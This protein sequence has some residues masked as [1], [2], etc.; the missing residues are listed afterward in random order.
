MPD[1]FE[2]LRLQQ[3][4]ARAETAKHAHELF[5]ARERLGRLQAQTREAAR[6]A[7]KEEA[8]QQFAD[9]QKKAVAGVKNASDQYAAAVAK[10]KLLV[11]SLL[12][13]TDPR[14]AIE[15]LDDGVPILM[16]PV[17]IETRFRP[18]LGELW[19]RVYPDDCSV[20]TFEP[21]LSEDELQHVRAYWAGIFQAG[22]DPNQE[23]GAW[24]ALAA[25]H[26]PGRAEWLIAQHVPVNLAMRMT[27]TKPEDVVLT[28]VTDEPLP[29]DAGK[30]AT[31]WAQVWQADGDK[32]K[33]DAAAALLGTV[34]LEQARKSFV[35]TNVQAN[36]ELPL[37]RKD[38]TVFVEWVL[39]P[40]VDTENL[41][42]RAWARAATVDTLPDRFV[43]VGYNPGA[44][45]FV[46]VGN[47]IPSSLSVGPDPAAPEEQRLHQRQDDTGAMVFPDEMQWMVDFERAV[48]VGM[49]FRISLQAAN[50]TGGFQRVLVAGVRLTDTAD[51]SAQRLETLIAHHRFS[52]S[53]FA[54]VPQGT[55]TNNTD[56]GPAG[57]SR[58]ADADEAF[59]LLSKPSLFEDESDPLRKRDGQWLAEYLGIDPAALR[60]VV[61]ADGRDQSDARAMNVALWP[62]TLGYWMESMM[63]PLLDGDL[64]V[65]QTRDFFTRFVSGRGAI[66]AV[67]IGKQ[68]YGILPATAFSHMDWIG[69]KSTAVSTPQAKFLREL[70]RVL[71]LIG[72]DWEALKGLQGFAGKGGDP[73]QTLL[74]I[75]GLH[76]GSAELFQRWTESLEQLASIVRLFVPDYEPDPDAWMLEAMTHLQHLAGS[77]PVRPPELLNKFFIGKRNRVDK[78]IDTV[79]LSET[80]TLTVT[81]S[82]EKNYIE[83]L[84]AAAETSL[85][86]LYAQEGFGDKPPKELLYVMLRHALQLGY[87]DISLRL[88]V[89]KDLMT[90][91]AARQARIDQ[92]F[93]NIATEKTVAESRYEHLFKKE[94]KITGS[95]VQRVDEFI[96][97]SLPKLA[98]FQFVRPLHD[99]IAA[100]KQLQDASTA[101]LERAFV[102]HI[103]TCA[104]RLDSWILGLV[105]LQLARMRQI[106][107]DKATPVK[108]GI[109]LGAYA[110]VEDLRPEKKTLKPKTFE[111]D[112][113]LEKEFG[114][115]PQLVRDSNNFGYI[116]APSL[117]QAVAAAV[118]RNGYKQNASPKNRDTLAVNLTSERVRAAMAMIEGIR[119]GQS[120]GALLGYQF[121]RGLHDRHGEAEVDKFIFDLRAKFPLAGNKL[122]STFAA[123]LKDVR[124]I[125]A[126]NVVDGLA[127]VEHMRKTG[128]T[129]YPF[130]FD[131]LPHASDTEQVAI[132]KEAD[133]MRETHDA[134]SDL[135]TAEG[136]YQAILGNYDRAGS[137]YDAY[138][139]GTLPPEPQVVRAPASGKALT[140]RVALHLDPD[141]PAGSTPRSIAEPPL[142]AWLEGVL[143]AL[144]DIG[145]TVHFRTPGNVMDEMS[146]TLANLGL[147]ARDV[148][149]LVH[150]GRQAMN[151]LDDRI[152]RFV[153]PQTR[154]DE[155]V[156]IEYRK[157]DPGIPIF[158]VM[159][160]VR[161]LRTLFD[162]ARPLRPTDL[163][164]AREAATSDD[165]ALSFNASAIMAAH[166]RLFLANGVLGGYIATHAPLLDDQAA[167]HAA[168]VNGIDADIDALAT[169]LDGAAL[170]GI[171]QTGW[172]FAYDTRRGVY[173][174]I[175]TKVAEA[176]QKLA[177]RDVEFGLAMAGLPAA[178][179]DAERFDLLYRAERLISTT[180]T[181][182]AT[183]L[184]LETELT[185]IK[186]P[187]F[188]TQ[189]GLLQNVKNTSAQT[190]SG[191]L[192]QVKGLPELAPFTF[193]NLSFDDEERTLVALAED[194]FRLAVAVEAE[195]KKR[196]KEAGDLLT[197]ANGAADAPARNKAF[198]AAAKAMFG[199]HFTVIPRFHLETKQANEIEQSRNAFATGAPLD[200]LISSPHNDPFPLDTWLYGLARVRDKLRAWEQTVVL[201]EAFGSIQPSLEPLQF[202]FV[203]KEPWLGLEFPP[204]VK[205]DGERL[206]YTGAYAT[207]FNKLA[208]QCGVL[209]DEWAEIIPQ[210]DLDTGIAFHF[211]RPNNEAPQAML[212]VTPSDKR[213]KWIWSDVVDALNDTLDFAKR[214]AVEP[215]DLQ[216]TQYPRFLPATMMAVTFGQLSISAAMIDANVKVNL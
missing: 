158:E 131:D 210:R 162:G 102:D 175:L 202:P 30:I 42:R 51:E 34:L 35:P 12:A 216:G 130:G 69:A 107:T 115:A 72:A 94:Q 144:S 196:H 172:G 182:A 126:R 108:R 106:D 20:D 99:Q 80:A 146:V 134:V 5:L 189:L 6:T 167:N 15:H 165:D 97:A 163:T 149:E 116:H 154:P 195:G 98:E 50:A 118:L 184:A 127:F 10:E 23:R 111:G 213:G 135:A 197:K 105:H 215:D 83:W 28:I 117:N 19:V 153:M 36:P 171:P 89:E 7:G 67:R 62:A 124:E 87:H 212:L 119:N 76:S 150:D 203:E 88:H 151:E 185:T 46:Q 142:N 32:G 39:V 143:P 48:E 78:P 3:Q 211:D 194:L 140:H 47:V 40:T 43:F 17:R 177:D 85:A 209:L 79:P 74:K 155:P 138:A 63:K 104:Y 121:E 198:D 109:Y 59:D 9:A 145:C 103:D 208:L 49:G 82:D 29:A 13:A 166:G 86:A 188:V 168:I 191:L 192:S 157:H 56:S 125:E 156:T 65:E 68:P 193:E 58:T 92:P 24:R 22:R 54:L 173:K 57:W 169:A 205:I 75:V 164:L 113:E 179:T 110:W 132:D 41:R 61:H 122:K 200:H 201:S 152:T 1:P 100:L 214:R 112:A 27:K 93:L 176:A 55:P 128:K 95:P 133:R 33:E 161:S 53:G 26:G 186:H 170:F 14:T 81:R 160:L 174:A 45:P 148:L 16:L 96:A 84:I 11:P 25:S 37:R 181:T 66:P 129:S 31:Y 114:G 8:G 21:T 44:A 71:R 120:L 204:E 73:H 18:Q 178:L 60:R 206:L 137:T 123:L 139:K 2:Q 101:R 207:A 70:D 52:R 38:V 190:V 90:E 199:E 187:A 4:A 180:V 183:P 136:V 147:A 64:Q 91:G 159:P 141:A 77:T